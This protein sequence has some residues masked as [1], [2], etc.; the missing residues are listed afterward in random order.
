[1]LPAPLAL[2]DYGYPGCDLFLTQNLVCSAAVEGFQIDGMPFPA[3][4]GH[5]SV[6]LLSLSGGAPVGLLGELH[7]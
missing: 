5:H 4:L 3:W 1:M 6:G 2:W 7:P